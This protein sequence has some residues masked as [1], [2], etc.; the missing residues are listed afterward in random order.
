MLW[1][2]KMD[3]VKRTGIQIS[4][5]PGNKEISIVG[6]GIKI[7]ASEKPINSSFAG[8]QG[9]VYILLDCSG[10]M[11]GEKIDQAR[12]GIINFTQDAFKKEYKVGVIKFSSQAEHLCEPTSDI[13]ILKSGIKDIRATGGTN[14]T[15]A[16]EMAR[17]KLRGYDSTKVMVI[18]TDGMPDNMKSSLAAAKYARD[19]GIEIITI[20]TD[21]AHQDFLKLL[22][23]RTELSSKVTSDNLAQ[24]IKD[25]SLLLMSP[26][27][28]I[29]NK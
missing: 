24:A 2:Y 17:E 12:L 20:G 28:I 27:L 29:P 8:T 7:A 5:Q 21:D 25:A 16:I 22:A 11:K 3:N 15:E 10:S 4:Q 18:A 14:L 6:G 23:S 9:K 13:E 26:K 19:D 1:R